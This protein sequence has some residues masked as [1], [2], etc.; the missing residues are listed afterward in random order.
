MSN[1]VAFRIDNLPNAETVKRQS[2][3]IRRKAGE[4]NELVAT[5]G[6]NSL[7]DMALKRLNEGLALED[8]ISCLSRAWTVATELRAAAKAT[9]TEG[10]ERILVP[11]SSHQISQ[12]LCPVVTL[13]CGDVDLPLEFTLNLSADIDSIDL[14]VQRGWFTAIQAGRFTPAASLSFHGITL[15]EKAAPPI[16]LVDAYQLAD[17]GFQIISESDL[18]AHPGLTVEGHPIP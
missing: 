4:A 1:S 14:I 10:P 9:I 12:E 3:E 13:S 2:N 16:E 11:L 6:W 15:G 17:G 5:I 8:G 18:P 7:R